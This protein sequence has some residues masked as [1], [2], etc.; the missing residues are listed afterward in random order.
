M[1][2]QQD[3][4]KN[5]K[6]TGL[7]IFCRKTEKFCSTELYDVPLEGSTI[8][9]LPS[10]TSRTAMESCRL[11]EL[12]YAFFSRT[13]LKTKKLWRSNG[14]PSRVY[15]HELLK[16]STIIFQYSFITRTPLESSR[17]AELKYAISAG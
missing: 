9:L 1:E 5:E 13:R 12:K 3:W 14:F 10:S 4:P 16:G 17:L 7:L 8:F 6:I 15:K 11:A 2:F